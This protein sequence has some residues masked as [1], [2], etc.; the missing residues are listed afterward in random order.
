MN[1]MKLAMKQKIVQKLEFS[2]ERP[3]SKNKNL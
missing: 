3:K 2:D 1:V